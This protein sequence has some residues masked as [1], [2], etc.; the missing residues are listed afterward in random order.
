MS[1]ERKLYQKNEFMHVDCV[2]A[3]LFKVTL[4]LE[5]EDVHM[6]DTFWCHFFPQYQEGHLKTIDTE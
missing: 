5:V 6:I 4:L 1:D 2:T 3:F